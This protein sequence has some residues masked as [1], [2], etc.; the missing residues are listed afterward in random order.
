MVGYIVWNVRPEIFKLSESI[1]IIGGFSIRWYGLLFASSFIL[2]Y[3]IVQQFFK[4][5]KIAVK[6]LDSL[7][8]YMVIFTILGARL[9]HVFF[10]EP[11][12][13]LAHPIEILQIW[14]GGLASHGA[15]VGILLGIYIFARRN[16]LPFLWVMDRVVIPVALAGFFI[17]TGNLMNSEIFGY[18]TTLPWGF[19]F[20]HSADPALAQ[21]AHHPTQIYEGL[22]YLLIFFFLYRYYWKNIDRGKL[23]D[24][25]IFGYFLL[26]VFSMRFLIEFLKEPQEVWEQHMLLNMG[27]LLSIPLIIAGFFLLWW[28]NKKKVMYKVN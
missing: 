21:G 20:V 22:S 14:K 13:F 12:Y 1:P 15:A 9:G 17:R 19:I 6:L 8:T 26:L 7:S 24:G 16:K 10:Y 3:L 11:T 25:K 28:S 23:Y 2:G 27:Q 18:Q 4:K 5:E